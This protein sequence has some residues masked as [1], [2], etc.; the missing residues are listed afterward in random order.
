MRMPKLLLMVGVSVL[1]GAAATPGLGQQACPGDC[2]GDRVVR[3][4]ELITIVKVA[5]GAAAITVCAAGDASADGV[6]Q[7]DEVVAAVNQALHGR[8]AGLE[9]TPTATPLPSAPADPLEAGRCYESAACE[10]CDV[11][12]CRPTSMTRDFCCSLA[13]SG[14]T[15]S[16]CPEPSFDQGTLACRECTYPCTGLATRTPSP[17]PT[18]TSCRAVIPV[19]APVQSPTDQLEQLVT[20]CGIGYGTSRVNACGPAGC[21]EHFEPVAHCPLRCPDS[22]QACV[23]GALPLLPNQLNALQVCQ[24]PGVGCGPPPD[25]CAEEDVNGTPLAIEQRSAP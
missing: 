22:R 16:W 11:Y 10:P 5:L 19:V 21:V 9:P 15:F 17:M 12:P 25:L 14:G 18:P 24:V 23:T 2:D 1:A 6:V 13:R 7:V 4:G 20:L 3:I 8:C